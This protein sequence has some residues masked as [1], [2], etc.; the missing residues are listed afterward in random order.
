MIGASASKRR[1]ATNIANAEAPGYARIDLSFEGALADAVREDNDRRAPRRT[2][3]RFGDGVRRYSVLGDGTRRGH[4]P[5]ARPA[6]P[7]P[8]GSTFCDP[9]PPTTSRSE[10]AVAAAS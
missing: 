5:G 2:R 7:R 4:V 8:G 6:E 9:A 1:L 10:G 3:P